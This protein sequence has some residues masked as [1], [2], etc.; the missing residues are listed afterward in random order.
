MFSCYGPTSI[1]LR[2]NVSRGSLSKE[3]GRSS[4]QTKATQTQ[5]LVRVSAVLEPQACA[6]RLSAYASIEALFASRYFVVLLTIFF[7]A[8]ISYHAQWQVDI[9]YCILLPWTARLRQLLSTRLSSR[10]SKHCSMWLHFSTVRSV[11]VDYTAITMSPS[12]P[13]F[14]PQF[15]VPISCI[16]PADQDAQASG[17]SH[18]CKQCG[19]ARLVH[20]MD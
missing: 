14:P 2:S 17:W 15:S 9:C 16:V 11:I 1:R 5:T 18:H 10:H 7:C 19:C 3:S 6:L 20:H 12:R 4:P 8:P 13:N